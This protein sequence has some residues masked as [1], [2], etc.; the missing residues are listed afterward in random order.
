MFAN[1]ILPHLD[2]TTLEPSFKCQ[3]VRISLRR[4][5]SS[6]LHREN[7]YGFLSICCVAAFPGRSAVSDGQANNAAL[8]RRSW[9]SLILV[10]ARNVCHFL[11]GSLID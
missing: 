9:V 8:P 3:E 4:Q 1:L 5:K 7:I 6:N 2:R 10:D 11:R